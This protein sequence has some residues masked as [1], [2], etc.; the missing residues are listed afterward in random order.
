MHVLKEPTLGNVN[1]TEEISNAKTH[2]L[3]I[4]NLS[5][6]PISQQQQLSNNFIHWLGGFHL[7]PN[8]VIARARKIQSEKLNGCKFERLRL[9]FHASRKDAAAAA[10]A[11]VE[12]S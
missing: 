8:K 1:Q 5:L 7:L 12:R 11:A 10:A 2:K 3:S 9:R 4:Y 6:S